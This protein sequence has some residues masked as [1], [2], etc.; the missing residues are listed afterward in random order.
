MKKKL[1][2]A[3]SIVFILI[4]NVASS[5]P[6][7]FQTKVYPLPATE[8]VIIQFFQQVGSVQDIGVE[9]FDIDGKKIKQKIDYEQRTVLNLIKEVKLNISKLKSGVYF[10]QIKYQNNSFTAKILVE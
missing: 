3:L 1:T 4:I 5:L 9:L 10:A 7:L 6:V 2:L 8:Y